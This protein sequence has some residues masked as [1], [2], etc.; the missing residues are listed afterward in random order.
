M[1]II[2]KDKQYILQT[3]KRQNLAVSKG[4][5]KYLYDTDGKKYLD[6]FAGISVCNLGH[7]HPKVVAAIKKQ[8]SQLIH[9]S[10]HYYAEP[11]VEL[12][13][14]LV[15]L[16]FPGRVFLSNSGA[17]ANE[18]ALKLVRKWG[19]IQPS[20]KTEVVTFSNS[21][22]G[23]TLFTLAATGQAK[24]HKGFEPMPESFKYA[25][26]NNLASLEALV[27]D[28]T[29]AILL[30][31]VQGEG[32]INIATQEFMSGVKKICDEKNIILIF[33]EVQCGLG[34]T[35]GALF[36]TLYQVMVDFH[37]PAAAAWRTWSIQATSRPPGGLVSSAGSNGPLP[38]SSTS[39]V[40]PATFSASAVT[41]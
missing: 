40:V 18:C 28:K 17:E 10:N 1:N 38:V 39:P 30:E 7:C 2:E 14:K 16:S 41:V 31:P 33:D 13:E 27:S 37:P 3:Y 32:G 35:G 4:K 34:R 12:V 25:E 24:F 6:F 5:G 22:H 29:A 8:S 15:K 26:F 21:F 19:N 23:R 11:Q 20:K 36:C 9:A